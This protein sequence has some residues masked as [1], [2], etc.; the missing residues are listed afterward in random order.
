MS[1]VAH[2]I[3]IDYKVTNK[4]HFPLRLTFYLVTAKGLRLEN[5]DKLPQK[6]T[7]WPF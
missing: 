5:Q 6:T 2:F 3:I 1:L 7:G 4:C